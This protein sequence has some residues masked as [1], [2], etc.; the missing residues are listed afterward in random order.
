MPRDEW[1][2]AREWNKKCGDIFIQWG[3]YCGKVK[4][5]CNIP[6]KVKD[7]FLKKAK[8]NAEMLANSRCPGE[9]PAKR[10]GAWRAIRKRCRN[11][12]YIVRIKGRFKCVHKQGKK[13][14]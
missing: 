10:Q 5:C 11:N 14:K 7:Q 3:F 2:P 12:I 9:C 8:A 4:D 1:P 13:K 6:Q